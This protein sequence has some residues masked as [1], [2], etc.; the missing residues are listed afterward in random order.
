MEV[1]N[2]ANYAPATGIQQ[3]GTDFGHGA[4]QSDKLKMFLTMFSGEVLKAFDRTNVTQNRHTVRSIKHGKA[5]S[6][7]VLGRTTARYLEAGESLD[8]TRTQIKGTEKVITVDGLLVSD[9]LIADIED[10]MNH[11]DV[12]GEYSKQLG[13]SLAM[14]YDGAIFAE[15]A[16]A[17]NLADDGTNENLTGLGKPVKMV[18]PTQKSKKGQDPEKEGKEILQMLAKAQ[19]QL[20]TQYVPQGERYF[21]CKPEVYAAISAAFLPQTA[22]YAS[23]ADPST[24][25][26]KNIFGFEVIQVPHLTIGGSNKKGTQQHKFPDSSGTSAS[27]VYANIKVDTANVVGLFM[28]RSAI[29]TVKL[30]D[31]KI[32]RARRPELQS[33]MIIAKNSMGHGLL[34]PEALGFM[35]YTD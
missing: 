11:F 33:D 19:A 21:Y 35:I 20:N 27:G 8:E 31:M 26:L 25:T 23:L 10:A 29:G 7:P 2:M 14:S 22:N 24:G 15:I 13:E 12:R 5:A 18:I 16:K 30:R 34:R 28:H 1:F 6:F 4:S 3:I 17:G 9:V 32:E